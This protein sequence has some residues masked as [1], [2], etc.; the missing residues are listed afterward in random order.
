MF[1]L[2][3]SLHSKCSPLLANCQKNAAFTELG[4][5]MFPFLNNWCKIG[6][7]AY[8]VAHA[9]SILNSRKLFA[10]FAIVKNLSFLI[11]T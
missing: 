10:S 9:L 5:H 6:S 2:S 11:I 1:P 8:I 7:F 3:K 4:Q